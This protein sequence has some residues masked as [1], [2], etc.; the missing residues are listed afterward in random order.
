MVTGFDVQHLIVRVRRIAD[1]S[2]R[3]LAKR[4]G[5]SQAQVNR[6]E[7][8]HQSP[9]AATFARILAVAGLRLAVL[10]DAGH[11][12]QPVPSDTLRDNA[13]RR[14]PG[15]LDVD[16]PEEVPGE[17]VTFPRYDRPPARGWY[18]QRTLRDQ[19]RLDEGTPD[20][21][22]TVS[23]EELRKRRERERR[24]SVLRVH[25]AATAA[26]APPCTCLDECFELACTSQCRCQCESPAASSRTP[27]WAS[28]PEQPG[29]EAS[30]DVEHLG[31]SFESGLGGACREPAVRSRVGEVDD[32]AHSHPHQEPD[33]RLDGEVEDQVE[34]QQCR[35]PR[36]HGR[37]RHDEAPLEVRSLS[38][39]DRDRDGDEHEC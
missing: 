3:D 38:S 5:V 29:G 9:S 17:R 28:R 37:G 25:V 26:A 30:V 14:F 35:E 15:H 23:G 16:P 20:D 31:S 19:R 10:D 32:D 12:V 18:R 24:L 2:Q 6:L 11:E 39:Q 7:N 8:G 34:A 4:L 13:N 27:G 36:E 22:P 1:L 33:P 21:H